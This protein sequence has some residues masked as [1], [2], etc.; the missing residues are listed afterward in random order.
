MH[1]RI[2]HG[3]ISV[4]A[5]LPFSKAR[6]SLDNCM[7]NKCAC[8]MNSTVDAIIYGWLFVRKEIS[9]EKKSAGRLYTGSVSEL[10]EQQMPFIYVCVHMCIYV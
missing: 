8:N 7:E 9:P 10:G 6:T 2:S 4:H 5:H 1:N 3:L